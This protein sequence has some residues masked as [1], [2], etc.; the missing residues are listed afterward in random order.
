MVG[1]CCFSA[2]KQ[3]T[4]TRLQPEL[5]N[6]CL[7]EAVKRDEETSREMKDDNPISLLL[8]PLNVI[9]FSLS[10]PSALSNQFETKQKDTTT[11]N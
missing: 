5:N 4:P 11:T 3:H 10:P 6:Q 8:F 2:G 1:V 9:P 7:L